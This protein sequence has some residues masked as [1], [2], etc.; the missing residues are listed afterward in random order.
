MQIVSAW[1]GSTIQHSGPRRAKQNP[2]FDMAAEH[3]L[4][5]P[6]MRAGLNNPSLEKFRWFLRCGQ[7]RYS[8]SRYS[9]MIAEWNR[10]DD[11]FITTLL[12][13][14]SSI[15]LR[16]HYESPVPVTRNFNRLT[17]VRF[18]S[19]IASLVQAYFMISSICFIVSFH[20]LFHFSLSTLI[21]APAPCDNIDDDFFV[22]RNR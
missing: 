13:G 15:L 6:A 4:A 22:C 21:S 20:V 5:V 8:F 18:I 11:D 7:N 9:S 16:S 19:S 3:A 2:V 10:S 12:S 1:K 14:Y 17:P